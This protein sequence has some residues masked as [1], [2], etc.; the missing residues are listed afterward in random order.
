[1]TAEIT[2]LGAVTRSMPTDSPSV[3]MLEENHN[4]ATMKSTVDPKRNISSRPKAVEFSKFGMS[5]MAI[6][7]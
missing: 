1:M 4:A 7:E 3:R 6:I 5:S 2:Q